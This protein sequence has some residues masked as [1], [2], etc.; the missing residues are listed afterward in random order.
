MRLDMSV[1]RL[2]GYEEGLGRAWDDGLVR[3]CRPNAFEPARLAT[4]ELLGMEKPPTAILA[5]R[6]GGVWRP[7]GCSR[8]SRGEGAPADGDDE[9]SCRPSSSYEER[10][11]VPR[12]VGSAPGT[13]GLNRRYPGSSAAS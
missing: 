7:S 2:A 4:R 13:R 9:R 1:E 3:T 8:R 12:L 10:A 5:R 6:R 11:R